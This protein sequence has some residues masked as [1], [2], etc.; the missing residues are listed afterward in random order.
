MDKYHFFNWLWGCAC[1][2]FSSKTA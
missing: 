1:S 2:N